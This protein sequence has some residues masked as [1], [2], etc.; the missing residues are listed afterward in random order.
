MT[1]AVVERLDLDIERPELAV[2]VLVLDARVGELD[3]AVVVRKLVLDGPA[4]DLLRR[5]IG[6]AVAVGLPRLRSCRNSW[7]SRL[8]SLSRTTRRM[9]APSSRSR[10]ASFRYAR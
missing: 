2:A 8:S 1:A 4:M 7:Y 10:S 6:P 3:V 9:I 5:S